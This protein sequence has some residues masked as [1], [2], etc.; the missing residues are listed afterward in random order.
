MVRGSHLVQKMSASY[1]SLLK[2]EQ[3]K[4]DAIYAVFKECKKNTDYFYRFQKNPILGPVIFVRIILAFFF[5]RLSVIELNFDSC[6]FS[7]LFDRNSSYK[8]Q[9]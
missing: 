1:V 9:C 4:V 8:H 3:F 2:I 5:E 6:C 7:K